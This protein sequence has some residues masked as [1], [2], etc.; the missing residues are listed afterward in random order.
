MRDGVSEE[1]EKGLGG[2]EGKKG[3]P[4]SQVPNFNAPSEPTSNAFIITSRPL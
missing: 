3:K 1:R 4:K 2:R